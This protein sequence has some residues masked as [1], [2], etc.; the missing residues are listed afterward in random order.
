[1]VKVAKPE[2][3]VARQAKHS[4]TEAAKAAVLA[5]AYWDA[6]NPEAAKQRKAR[7]AKLLVRATKLEVAR[8]IKR[9]A[10]I[11]AFADEIVERVSDGE[12][13]LSVLRELEI[14]FVDMARWLQLNETFRLAYEKARENA[15]HRF[16]SEIVTIA[17][18]ARGKGEVEKIMIDARKWLAS[19][20]LSKMYGEKI[21]HA[22]DAESPLVTK[23]VSDSAELLA[24]IRGETK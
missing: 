3:K 20:V 12:D 11:P 23:L 4:V 16:I 8:A 2:S 13:V 7:E 1:M 22:G 15:A 5:Q 19:K 24:K 6:K 9:T 18:S 17:D 21:T 10:F 14:R